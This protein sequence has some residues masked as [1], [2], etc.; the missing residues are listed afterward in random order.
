M[1]SILM[2]YWILGLMGVG[3]V[4]YGQS[5]W[6]VIRRGVS[7]S[8]GSGFVVLY[9]IICFCGLKAMITE[10]HLPGTRAEPNGSNSMPGQRSF[11]QQPQ[12]HQS[13]PP[14]LGYFSAIFWRSG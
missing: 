12:I 13:N 9:F 4:V 5:P 11:I 2:D 3:V 14:W 6:L 7:G 10:I 8:R 1:E